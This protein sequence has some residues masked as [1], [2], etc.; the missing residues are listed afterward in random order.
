MQ[1]GE[2]WRNVHRVA[3]ATHPTEPV[4]HTMNTMQFQGYAT[5]INYSDADACFVGHIAGIADVVGFHADNVS[6]LRQA[7]EEAVTDYVATCLKAGRKPQ[8]A[9]SGKLMLRVPPEVHGAALV[10]AQVRGI[11]LN[12]WASQALRE[13]ALA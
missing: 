12:Q 6:D 2:M 3:H 10:A 7:F 13:A 4:P 11:S 9:A 8:K 1:H 5:Q